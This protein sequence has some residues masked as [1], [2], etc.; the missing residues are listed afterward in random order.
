MCSSGAAESLR[1][2]PEDT[3]E[4]EGMVLLGYEV[5]LHRPSLSFLICQVGV[6]IVRH[7]QGLGNQMRVNSQSV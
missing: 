6:I 3:G 4:D 7:T 5:L 2:E 1:E